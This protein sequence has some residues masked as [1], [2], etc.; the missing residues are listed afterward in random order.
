MEENVVQEQ[1]GGGGGKL[2]PEQFA[3]K[4]KEKYPQ[5]KDVE[6]NVLVDKM[7]AKYPQYKDQIAFPSQGTVEPK[8]EVA[9]QGGESKL[10]SANGNSSSDSNQEINPL[11]SFLKERNNPQLKAE[12]ERLMEEMN[13]RPIMADNS[14]IKAKLKELD[15]QINSSSSLGQS[16]YAIA[17]EKISDVDKKITD[18][19]KKAEERSRRT[20][21]PMSEI[22]NDGTYQDLVATKNNYKDLI[23]VDEKAIEKIKEDTNADIGIGS[24]VKYIGRYLE[25]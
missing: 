24:F 19:H 2:S 10:S 8:G 21:I 15:K 12:K 17:K 1:N 7:I 5:Y 20:G 3:K 25:K 6:D 4:V 22:L 9:D 11:V 23:K 14:D 16:T 13:S 18:F